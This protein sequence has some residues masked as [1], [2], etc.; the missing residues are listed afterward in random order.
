MATL[1]RK[2]MRPQIPASSILK[3]GV[4]QVC[5]AL[6]LSLSHVGLGRLLRPRI[7]V[8]LYH[9]VSDD[10]R[11]NLTVGIEQFD[12]QMALIRRHCLPLSIE[13]VLAKG[14]LLRS[15]APLVA[16][17][18]DDGYLDNYVNAVPIL[19]RHGIP[20]AFFVSTGIV[21]SDSR[22]P[23]D[24]QR[25]NPPIPVMKWDQ[26]RKMRDWGFTIGSHCENH[27]DCAAEPE[28]RVRAELTQSRDKLRRELGVTSPLFAF[29]YGRRQNMTPQRLEFVKQAGYSACFSAYGGTNVGNIDPYNVLRRGIHWEFSDAAFLLECLGVR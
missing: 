6:A 8:L 18:F 15:D 3:E 14:D 26:L 17:T 29:P 27:I 12:R 24:V 1:E 20:A 28:E 4:K 11:D 13:Q 25:G 9:R 19:M 16:V 21:D 22:F 2:L 10:A 7:T 23:H 5:S